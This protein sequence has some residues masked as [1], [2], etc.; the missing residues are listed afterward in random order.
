VQTTLKVDLNTPGSLQIYLFD[1]S[2]RKLR[3]SS[4]GFMSPGLYQFPLQVDDLPR[5]T[6]FVGIELNGIH[7]NFKTLVVN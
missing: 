2:G 7:R 5:G 1:S 4:S 3:Q 6:Y